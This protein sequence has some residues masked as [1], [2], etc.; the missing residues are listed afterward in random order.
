MLDYILTLITVYPFYA[1]IVAFILGF[2]TDLVWAKW[3]ISTKTN[4]A[5]AAANLSV[6]IYIFGLIYTLFII[7]KNILLIGLYMFGGWVGTFMAVRHSK[8]EK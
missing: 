6:F 8:K 1:A 7:E 3:A 4:R 2:F 5:L